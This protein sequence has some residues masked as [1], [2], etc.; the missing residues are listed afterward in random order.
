MLSCFAKMFTIEIITFEFLIVALL[1]FHVINISCEANSM[2]DAM[3][4]QDQKVKIWPIF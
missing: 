4:Q 2:M 3:M 1:L